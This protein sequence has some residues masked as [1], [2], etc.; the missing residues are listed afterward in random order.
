LADYIYKTAGLTIPYN[1]TLGIY[2][3]PG[4]GF[5]DFQ[6]R[7]NAAAREARD[8]EIDRTTS[9]FE[10]L[11]DRLEER[12]RR[13]ERELY[14]DRQQVQ[15][16]G[17]E[18][19]FTLGE[20]VISL[21]QGRTNYTLSRVS[22]TRRFKGQAKEDVS[23]SVAVLRE[24]EAEMDNL[25]QRFE[26]ELQMIN[27]KWQQIA[28]TVEEVRVTPMKKDIHPE[29]F[30]VCWMPEYLLTINGQQARLSAWE[31]SSSRNRDEA[32]ARALPPASGGYPQLPPAQ[33]DLSQ[34]TYANP[35]QQGYSTPG[36]GTPAGG[37]Q[38]YDA[39][40]GYAYPQEG[41]NY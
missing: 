37:Q 2:G 21:M 35:P 41:P 25:Q 13:E 32:P 4:T 5:R 29:L 14:A 27:N 11:F 28:G 7:V 18:E 38:D 36:Y 34:Q 19:L 9:K 15:D 24:I 40:D 10:G 23:E 31:S 30:G 12:Y 3:V 6:M 20:A 1:S 39:D 22:R 17:Q 26:Y 8:A 33:P 16:L